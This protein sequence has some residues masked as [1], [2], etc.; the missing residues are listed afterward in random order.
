MSLRDSYF[1]GPSGLQQ[2][3]DAAFANGIAY[4]G[5]G[6]NDISTLS[7][8]NRNGS[9]LGAGNSNPGFY[10]SYATPTANYIMWM[11]INGEVAPSVAGTMVQVTILSSDNSTAV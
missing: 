6:A 11:F 9:N 7:L 8:G 10:F 2:Q 1:N 5:V 4:V 3:M